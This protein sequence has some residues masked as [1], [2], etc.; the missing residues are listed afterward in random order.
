VLVVPPSAQTLEEWRPG[1]RTLLRVSSTSG[2]RDLCVVEQWHD[3]G[4]GAPTHTHRGVEEVIVVLEGTAEFWVEDER[5]VLE[6]GSAI[7]LPADSRHGFRNIGTSVLHVLATLADG[8]PPVEY[9]GDSAGELAIGARADAPH[10]T[11]GGS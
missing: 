2:A 4:C 5:A 10:R 1:V 11:P 6:T 3:P 7:V 9:E 8:A